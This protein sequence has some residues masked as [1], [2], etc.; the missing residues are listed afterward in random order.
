MRV[1]HRLAARAAIQIRMHHLPDDRPGPDDRHL[2]DDVVERVGLQP[3]QRR[4]LRARLDLEHADRVGLAQHPVDRRI[5]LRQVREI[6]SGFGIR[7]SGFAGPVH[8]CRILNRESRFV[9]QRQRVLD[10]RHHAEA[11]QIHLDDA[12][13][14]AVVLVPLHDDAARHARVLER[15]DGVEL[16]PADHHAARVLAEMPRQ[17]VHPVPQLREQ[18]DAI[19]VHVEADR[20]HLP[21]Q[22]LAR[23]DELEVVHHLR[24]PVDLRRIEPERLP[25]LARRAA[26]A[27]GDHVGG[28]RGAEPAVFFVDVLD[29]AARGDRRSAD[30]DRCPATRRAPPRG[31]ARRADPC[32]RDRPP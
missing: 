19:A 31:T 32:R 17:I 20:R 6:H 12:H 10:H 7:A 14:G 1:A 11:E 13:V 18:A 26:A 2:H 4:H 25:H 16:A 24:E 15:H 29:H 3:R 27:V 23:V 22:R 5:V 30:R 8:R 21:R 28:H 9:H